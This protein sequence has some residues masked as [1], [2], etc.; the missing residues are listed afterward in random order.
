MR[1][2][3]FEIPGIQ[4]GEHTLKGR[5]GAI[6][7]NVRRNVL[8]ANILDVGCA[9]GLM[10]KWLIDVCRANSVDG[11]DCHEPYLEMARKLMPGYDARFFHVDL[12]F[13]A[14]W[15]EQN[16]GVLRAR[17]DLVL[18]TCIVQKM[19]RPADFLRQLADLSGNLILIQAP[20]E[21]IKDE[22]SSYVPVHI[23]NTLAPEFT[24][25]SRVMSYVGDFLAVYQ[26]SRL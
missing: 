21:V 17:Y 3:W 25:I 18:A 20:A 11:I 8:G 12:N 13:L 1:H 9:E 15:R 22:R 26:R 16:P 4:T 6:L 7:P 23:T 10:S 5:L 19:A 24:P 14:L 2:G